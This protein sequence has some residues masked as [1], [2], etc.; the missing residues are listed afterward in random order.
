MILFFG[1]AGSG[2]STQVELLAEEMNWIHFSMG[3]YLRSIDDQKIQKQVASGEMVDVKVTNRA[4]A[5]A[6][7]MAA[8]SGQKLLV[9]GYPRIKSQADWLIDNSDDYKVEAVVVID[10]KE[11][12][13]R[14]RLLERGRVD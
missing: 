13:I 9:D 8:E 11:A 14:K 4:L 12:E 7:E 10:V 3:A 2:K 5:D 1:L 6:Y